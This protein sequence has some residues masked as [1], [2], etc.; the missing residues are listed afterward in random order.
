M[1][2][3]AP[4][5][6]TGLPVLRRFA[7]LLLWGCGLFPHA[8]LAAQDGWVIDLDST[9][10]QK[11]P[12]LI[13]RQ[14]SAGG[15]LPRPTRVE[16]WLESADVQ[17]TPP[18]SGTVT[19]DDGR[20]RFQ[21][22][23]GL[24]AGQRYRLEV[25]LPDRRE[26]LSLTVPQTQRPPAEVQAIYPSGRQIPENTLRFYIDFSLPMQRGNVYDFLELR[27][28][29][30]QPVELPFLEIEQEL[31][32]RDGTRLT[33]LIDPGRIKR[34]LKPRRD[35][36]PVFEAGK[37]Y[38][39]VVAGD[40]PDAWGRKLGKEVRHSYEAIAADEQQ[41]LP[42]SWNLTTPRPG[43]RNPLVIAFPESLDAGM[44]ARMIVVGRQGEG[45]LAGAGLPGAEERSWEFTPTEPWLEGHYE[46]RVDNLLED[47][48]GNSI[49]KRFDVDLFEELQPLRAGTSVLKFSIGRS[50]AGDSRSGE[51][52]CR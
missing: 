5:S 27:G 12:L 32:S 50:A 1:T 39:L 46:I 20:I 15:P 37:T 47:L 11:T 29:E 2:I 7:W 31:W 3:S 45:A 16:M 44:L 14:P 51:S 23:Y 52:R 19:W 9:A 26:R 33:L 21:P 6:A 35:M 30:G 42:A 13:S 8:P 34:G 36:G 41:P 25:I 18:V 38:E 10:G 24:V 40:W 28:P 22:R 49:E 17:T 48:A 43:T 4:S